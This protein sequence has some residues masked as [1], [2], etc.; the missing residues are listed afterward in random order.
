MHLITHVG[1]QKLHFTKILHLEYNNGNIIEK[2]YEKWSLPG[3]SFL[4]LFH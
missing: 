4:S 3:T 1:S 2:I